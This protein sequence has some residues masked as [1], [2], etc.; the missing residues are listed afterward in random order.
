MVGSGGDVLSSAVTV[1]AL[2]SAA[3]VGN[4]SVDASHG[5]TDLC[6]CGWEVRL[7]GQCG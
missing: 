3:P 5:A 4:V 7:C 6:A 1:S 2:V